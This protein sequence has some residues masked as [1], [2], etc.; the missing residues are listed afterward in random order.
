M[1]KTDIDLNTNTNSETESNL[2]EQTLTTDDI[3]DDNL[4]SFEDFFEEILTLR[5]YFKSESQNFE[6]LKIPSDK[7]SHA[8]INYQ[9]LVSDT[10]ITLNK[11]DDAINDFLAISSKENATEELESNSFNESS[12]LMKVAMILN[13]EKPSEKEFQDNLGTYKEQLELLL[14]SE[15]FTKRLD[16]YGIRQDLS[17]E[18]MSKIVSIVNMQPDKGR[19]VADKVLPKEMKADYILKNK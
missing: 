5:D 2:S 7:A 19:R 8:A 10:Y 16:Q 3:N 9:K 12:D 1:P 11:F 14:I 4:Y 13:L 17:K 18:A 6:L 15:K